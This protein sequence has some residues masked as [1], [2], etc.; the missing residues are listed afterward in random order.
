METGD[1]IMVSDGQGGS[2]NAKQS[3]VKITGYRSDK[4]IGHSP[5]IF[6]SRQHDEKEFE[7]MCAEARHDLQCTRKRKY[8]AITNNEFQIMFAPIIKLCLR[9][10]PC[11]W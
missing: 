7:P 10:Q 2:L 3:F 1:G 8:S 6:N 4:I 5:F 11:A 9:T